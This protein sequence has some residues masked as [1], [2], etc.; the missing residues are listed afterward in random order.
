MRL[1]PHER[2]WTSSPRGVS[3]RRFWKPCCRILLQ[4]WKTFYLFVNTDNYKLWLQIKPLVS[5]TKAIMRVH[6][7]TYAWH[8][9]FPQGNKWNDKT[10][11]Y[12]PFICFLKLSYVVLQQR[13]T[14]VW[15]LHSGLQSF[16]WDYAS[17]LVISFSLVHANPFV[18]LLTLGMYTGVFYGYP[19]L[20]CYILH[21]IWRCLWGIPSSW[22]G[23]T[24][25]SPI[26]VKWEKGGLLL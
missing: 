19:D 25:L 14:L 3:L 16:L 26:V 9:F 23:L 10:K 1:K 17:S 13:T 15:W 20:V 2:F 12:I 8:E 5:P 7:R 22:R 11:I 21:I 6:I 18:Q 4:Y 24:N